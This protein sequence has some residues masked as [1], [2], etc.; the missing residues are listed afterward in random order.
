MKTLNIDN[1]T[2]RIDQFSKLNIAKEWV[3]DSH[4]PSAVI[5]GDDGFYWVVRGRDAKILRDNGYTQV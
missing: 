4:I 3:S 5:V 1:K 2:I